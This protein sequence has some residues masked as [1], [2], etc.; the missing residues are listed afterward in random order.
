M[1]TQTKDYQKKNKPLFHKKL[2]VIEC[3]DKDKLLAFMNVM[4]TVA[5]DME[6]KVTDGELHY[7]FGSDY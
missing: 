7:Y 6:I 5:S 2:V 3:V 1:K 4:E